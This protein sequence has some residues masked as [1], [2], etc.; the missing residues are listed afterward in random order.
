MSIDPTPIPPGAAEPVADAGF[1]TPF[2]QALRQHL[3]GEPEP[4]DDG[5]SLR[6][7]AALP[8]VQVQRLS[9]RSEWI[10]RAPWVAMSLA[11]SGVAL[12][13][14]TGAGPGDTAPTWASYALIGLMIF[15][16]VPSRW[17]RG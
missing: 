6:V 1:D 12:L 5:F 11:G 7:M 2:D 15:W 17:S 10:A 3:H 8:T 4:E 13:W 9:R 14:P 16:A